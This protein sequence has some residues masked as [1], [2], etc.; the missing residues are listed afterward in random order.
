MDGL[1]AARPRCRFCGASLPRQ[2]WVDYCH[3]CYE[4]QRCCACGLPWSCPQGT[5]WCPK[6][7][8]CWANIAQLFKRHEGLRPDAKTLEEN[9]RKYAARAAVGAPLFDPD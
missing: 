2:S 4:A 3:G 8:L 9:L 7:M 5:A 6:C 1:H